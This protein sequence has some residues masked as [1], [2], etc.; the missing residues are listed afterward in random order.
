MR[1][2]NLMCGGAK[3]ADCTPEKWYDFMGNYT[4]NKYVPFQTTYITE[5]LSGY[6]P[7]N[8]PTI[9]CSSAVDVSLNCFIKLLWKWIWYILIISIQ[10]HRHR[11]GSA[12]APIAVN[13]VHQIECDDG[14]NFVYFYGCAS[15]N[16]KKLTSIECCVFP[17]I[18]SV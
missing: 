3:D 7:F 2:L 16:E 14:R 13:L 5:P 15:H 9:A 18:C 1:A 8:R 4:S 6:I 17:T 12:H 11:K 10:I